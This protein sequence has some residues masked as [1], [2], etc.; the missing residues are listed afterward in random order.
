MAEVG[1]AGE[2]ERME[3][4]GKQKR[5]EADRRGGEEGVEERRRQK[6]LASSE[7]DRAEG[8]DSITRA[9][10]DRAVQRAQS[11]L[12]T[13]DQRV[14]KLEAD[15][16]TM[17]AQYVGTVFTGEDGKE[18]AGSSTDLD[19]KYKRL[20]ELSDKLKVYEHQTTKFGQNYIMSSD[21]YADADEGAQEQFLAG[22]GMSRDEWEGMSERQQT[23]RIAK[24]R[25]ASKEARENFSGV[26]DELSEALALY[27]MGE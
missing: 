4:Q 26:R 5:I 7:K 18:Y 23:G 1:V 27:G 24:E 12:G 10:S 15:I 19:A 17:R 16:E 6:E 8:K 3:I 13:A 14:A 21:E 22:M 25:R 2:S 11:N 9:R 20:K